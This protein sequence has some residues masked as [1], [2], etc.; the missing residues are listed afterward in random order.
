MI[1]GL[2]DGRF[3]QEGKAVSTLFRRDMQVFIY[4]GADKDYAESCMSSFNRMQPEL[5]DK[6]CRAAVLFC[7]DSL[8]SWA[9][10]DK[11]DEIESKMKVQLTP[12]MPPERILKCLVPKIMSVRRSEDG[13]V[14]YQVEFDCDFEPDKG[15]EIVVLG[16]ELIYLGTFRDNSP[17]D[18]FPENDPQNYVNKL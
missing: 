4:N 17:W 6:L 7:I 12:D 13:Q 10:I 8:N 16:E 11:R 2:K 1:I 15:M 3:W 18:E 14:G 5:I 9:E